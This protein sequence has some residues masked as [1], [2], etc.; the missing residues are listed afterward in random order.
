[1]KK[2]LSLLLVLA[3][4]AISGFSFNKQPVNDFQIIILPLKVVVD[5]DPPI[6]VPPYHVSEIQTVN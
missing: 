4:V 2:R 6:I 1:M 5:I 3:F